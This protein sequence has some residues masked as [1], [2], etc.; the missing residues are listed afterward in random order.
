MNKGVHTPSTLRTTGIEIFGSA[1]L[2][3]SR[4]MIGGVLHLKIAPFEVAGAGLLMLGFCFGFQTFLRF[5][6]SLGI[7]KKFVL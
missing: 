4:G 3:V 5:F 6:R 7:R 1:V 2:R